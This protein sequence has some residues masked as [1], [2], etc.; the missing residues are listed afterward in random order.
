MCKHLHTPAAHCF[1]NGVLALA[2]LHPFLVK[3]PKCRRK[4]NAA[5]ICVFAP[6]N[7]SK[8][9]GL[10]LEEHAAYTKHEEGLGKQSL[11]EKTLKNNQKTIL[12]LENATMIQHTH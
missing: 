9:I 1:S 7:V 5:G 2:A 8:K 12:E 6:Q 3:L 11:L 10:K 4:N